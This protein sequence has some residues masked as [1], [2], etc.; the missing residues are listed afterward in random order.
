MTEIAVLPD[1]NLLSTEVF[2]PHPA[3]TGNLYGRD[4]EGACV[5]AMHRLADLDPW[6]SG[7]TV[8][9]LI[10]DGGAIPHDTD[11]DICVMNEWHGPKSITDITSRFDTDDYLETFR[12][13]Y[14][15][16]PCKTN[17]IDT[18]R[19]VVVDVYYCYQGFE[20][21]FV[22]MFA[23]GACIR[24][25]EH[26]LHGRMEVDTAWGRLVLPYPAE[27][28]LECRYGENWRVP[29]DTCGSWRYAP[30]RLAW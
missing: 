24:K 8:L 16:R 25:P 26:L 23:P 28:Y 22:W 6:V 27:E 12:V 29:E 18:K 30:G 4:A 10:R 13:C 7:G 19:G 14:D 11:V 20:D 17:L 5:D 21:G 15:G 1:H 2:V 3:E 9:G